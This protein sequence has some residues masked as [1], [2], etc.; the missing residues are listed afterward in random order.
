MSVGI[1]R[2]MQHGLDLA[3]SPLI[4]RVAHDLRRIGKHEVHERVNAPRDIV[5]DD[6]FA[7]KAVIALQAAGD[8]Q[9]IGQADALRRRTG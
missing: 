5:L 6:D 8:V 1:Q 9:P 3:R 4:R 7:L 2:R